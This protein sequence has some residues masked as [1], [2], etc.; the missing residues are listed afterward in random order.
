MKYTE[1]NIGGYN[2]K[3]SSSLEGKPL[4]EVP[5][6][7][8]DVDGNPLT[9]EEGKYIPAVYKDKEGRIVEQ[10]YK[11]IGGRVINKFRITKEIPKE[12]IIE[13][14]KTEVFGVIEK[15]SHLVEC[16]LLK[17]KFTKKDIAWKY[18]FSWGNGFSVSTAYLYIFSGEL[19]MVLSQGKKLE[20]V[21]LVKQRKSTIAKEVKEE[22]MRANE[23]LK[24]IV[25]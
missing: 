19:F 3:I 25:V 12:Q 21:E 10:K 14:P 23:M 1:V 20:A 18:P 17:E 4:I 2:A 24:E 8:V 9:K 7:Y 16:E 11:L 5:S 6:D 15:S 13:V 22:V